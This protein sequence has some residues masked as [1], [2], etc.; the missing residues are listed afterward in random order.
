MPLTVRHDGR[1]IMQCATLIAVPAIALTEAGH[2]RCLSR[3][4]TGQSKHEFHALGQM[5]L[6]Q[7][8]DGDL[9]CEQVAGRLTVCADGDCFD[10]ADGLLIVR[11]L[12]GALS[13]VGHPDRPVRKLLE[14]AHRF[15]TRWVRLDL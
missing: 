12:D 8:D 6:Y 2:I 5:A 1:C 9:R 3:D 13:V 11:T 4:Q 10:L 15:C 14:A 7:F